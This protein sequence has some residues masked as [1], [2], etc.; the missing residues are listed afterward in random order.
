MPAALSR[1][2][3]KRIVPAVEGGACARQA[4]L[5]YEVSPSTA[6]ARMQRVRATGSVAPGGRSRRRPVLEPHGN[7]LR[8]LVEAKPSITLVQLRAALNEPGVQVAALST[9]RLMIR[10]LG[11]SHQ[12]TC[13]EPPSRTDPMSRRPVAAGGRGRASW[14]QAGSCSGTRP[15]PRPTWSGV[16]AGDQEESAS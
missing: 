9:I 8:T 14:T 11:L 15:G 6:V 13:C 1:D 10:R 7:L 4:A 3:R 16:R 5:R 2:R 12:K